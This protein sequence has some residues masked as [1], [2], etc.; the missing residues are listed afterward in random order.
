VCCIRTPRLLLRAFR[1]SDTP[2]LMEVIKANLEYL[3]A[4]MAWAKAEPV[5]LEEK[6]KFVRKTRRN[7]MAGRDQAFAIFTPDESELIGAIG[8]HR[9]IGTGAR[10]I[11]YWI[12]EAHQRRG[13]TTEAAAAL[14]RIGFE[15]Q[16]LRRMEIH[17]DPNNL[18]S[19][20]V[21]RKLGFH[22]QTIVARRVLDAAST[23][24]DTTIWALNRSEF[25]ASPAASVVIEAL[26]R[27]G[28]CVL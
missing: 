25:F 14:V 26:D 11:G 16:L 24:R 17:T 18:A 19:V 5:S 23:P 8:S 9:R 28:R 15:L 27:R 12:V 6:A 1:V 3:R 20:G 2:R 21:A 13:L 10:E 7:T 22:H 4:S